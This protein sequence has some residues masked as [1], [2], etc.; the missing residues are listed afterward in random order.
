[1]GREL[2][3]AAGGRARLLEIAGARHDDLPFVAGPAYFRDVAAFV[4]EVTA[5]GPS[6]ETP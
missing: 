2:A 3:R 1:M 4:R 6:A 5:G